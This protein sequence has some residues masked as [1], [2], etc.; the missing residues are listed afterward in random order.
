MNTIVISVDEA[1]RDFANVLRSLRERGDRVVLVDGGETIAEITATRTADN[2][3]AVESEERK[4]PRVVYDEVT[5]FPLVT[6]R[7]GRRKITSEEIYAE[8]RNTFP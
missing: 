2:S 1:A 8:L 7:P 4:G 6:A 5:G 3:T